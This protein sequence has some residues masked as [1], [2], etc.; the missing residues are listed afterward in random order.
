MTEVKKGDRVCLTGKA[1]SRAEGE[2]H[3]FVVET[4]GRDGIWAFGGNHFSRSGFDIVVLVPP[5][6]TEPGLYAS[7][8]AATEPWSRPLLTLNHRGEWSSDGSG[9]WS[10]IS[11]KRV[12]GYGPLVR[13]VPEVKK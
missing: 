1:G 3:E 12:E 8:E 5:L 7:A 6:P 11:P 2:V 9:E 10:G 4:A 13:L